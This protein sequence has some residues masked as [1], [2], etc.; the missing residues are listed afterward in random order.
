[1]LIRLFKKWDNVTEAEN[2]ISPL[3]ELFLAIS[4]RMVPLLSVEMVPLFRFE[5]CHFFR[6]KWCHFSVSNG[7]ISFGSISAT[8]KDQV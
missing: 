4:V 7:A 2:Q 5:W 3:M 8:L 1:M 6:L